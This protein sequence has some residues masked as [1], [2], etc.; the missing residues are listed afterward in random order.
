MILNEREEVKAF[1]KELGKFP[2][3][4]K[5]RRDNELKEKWQKFVL[6][7]LEKDERFENESVEKM[8]LLTIDEL[9][10]VTKDTIFD[11]NTLLLIYNGASE[12]FAITPTNNGELC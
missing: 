9:I 12:Q 10:E 4:P 8:K 2:P 1:I 7:F 3:I 5:E 6:N 11:F